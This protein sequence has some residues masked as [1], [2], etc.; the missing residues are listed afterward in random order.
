MNRQQ[1]SEELWRK[2]FVEFGLSERFELIKRDWSSDHGRRAT[3]ACKTCGNIFITSNVPAIF[4]SKVNGL[5]CPQCGMKS[6]GSIQ[7]TKSPIHDEAIAFYLQGHTIAEVAERFNISKVQFEGERRALGIVKTQEQKKTSWKKSLAKGAEKGNKAQSE[8][9][10]IRRILLLNS[11]GFDYVDSHD[12]K[13]TIKC[14]TCGC[15]FE[16]TNAFISK[17]N[18]VCPEC[19]NAEKARQR[20]LRQKEKQEQIAEREAERIAKNPLGL[21]SY[22]LSIQEKY[23]AV[24]VCEVCGKQYSLRERMQGGDTKYCRDNGCCSKECLKKRARKARKIRE[25][26]Y[27]NHK[28]RARKYGC[29]FDSSVTLKALI[30]RNGLRCAICGEMCDPADHEWTDYTGPKHPTIDHIIPMSKGGGHV[31]SNVQIAHAICNSIKRDSL[32]D[33]T[34]EAS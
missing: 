4:R 17:G 33:D 29:A 21:S 9:A 34:H 25:R 19:V 16:R 20:R 10:R 11:L 32:E 7:W 23:D 15:R 5:T 13:T 1:S 26:G 28:G 30:K 24:R 31:W 14:R 6:D 22:Q 18:I 2:K 3:I 27:R 8:S 12:S